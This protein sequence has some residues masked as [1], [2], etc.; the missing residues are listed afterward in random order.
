[1]NEINVIIDEIR[2]I[3]ENDSSG[4]DAWHSLRV[5]NVALKIADA[6]FCDKK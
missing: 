5:Y 2:K 3:F 6:E 4:H 1:M